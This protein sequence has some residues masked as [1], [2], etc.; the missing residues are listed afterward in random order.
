MSVLDQ[1]PPEIDLENAKNVSGLYVSGLP[2]LGTS[3][4]VVAARARSGAISA[5]FTLP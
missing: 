5:G 1:P 2:W 3:A 4:Y